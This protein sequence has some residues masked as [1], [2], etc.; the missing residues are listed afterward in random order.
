MHSVNCNL[1]SSITCW[2]WRVCVRQV[3]LIYV[4]QTAQLFCAMQH[5]VCSCVVFDWPVICKQYVL[6]LNEFF[7]PSDLFIYE[8]ASFFEWLVLPVR[9]WSDVW[10]ETGNCL[11]CQNEALE[12]NPSCGNYPLLDLSECRARHCANQYKC[13]D[14]PRYIF[15]VVCKPCNTVLV[16][17]RISTVL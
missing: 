16:L 15:C 8:M 3:V 6:Y 14:G 11:R 13:V 10:W 5:A 1:H 12:L 7:I 17:C 2:L 9:S 4:C